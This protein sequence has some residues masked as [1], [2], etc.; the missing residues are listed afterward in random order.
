MSWIFSCVPRLITVSGAE[1]GQAHAQSAGLL[2]RG[3]EAH[4]A[5]TLVA[6]VGAARA[7]W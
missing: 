4:R 7:S 2:R 6:L 3:G 5:G 1:G